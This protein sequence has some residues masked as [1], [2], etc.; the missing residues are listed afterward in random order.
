MGHGLDDG[1]GLLGWGNTF[2]EGQRSSRCP[3]TQSF[4]LSAQPSPFLTPLAVS[5]YIVELAWTT[6]GLCTAWT[7][8][9]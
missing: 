4:S 7:G 5:S 8:S 6:C 3:S 9:D 2:L 1:R